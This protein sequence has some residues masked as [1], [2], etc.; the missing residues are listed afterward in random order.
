VRLVGEICS[1]G[2]PNEGSLKLEI[3]DGLG[4]N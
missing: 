3:W 2:Q 1:W 4:S